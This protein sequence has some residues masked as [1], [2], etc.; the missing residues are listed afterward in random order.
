MVLSDDFGA[1]PGLHGEPWGAAYHA[2]AV[3]ACVE[4]L[5]QS[6]QDDLESLFHR[7]DKMMAMA[8]SR[9]LWPRTR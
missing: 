6:Y 2:E 1:V 3:R 4:V 7:C 9:L 8:L 5:P